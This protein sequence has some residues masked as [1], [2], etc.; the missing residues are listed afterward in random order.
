MCKVP[1]K[2]KDIKHSLNRTNISTFL[3]LQLHNNIPKAVKSIP[4]LSDRETY[5]KCCHFE[6]G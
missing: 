4:D 1:T 2:A 3:V 5:A 6:F